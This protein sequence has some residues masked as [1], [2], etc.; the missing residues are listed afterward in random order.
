LEKGRNK[1]FKQLLPVGLKISPDELN[2][3]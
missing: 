1:S 3:L 2:S